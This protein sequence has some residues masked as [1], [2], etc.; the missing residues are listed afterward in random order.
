VA[1]C[2]EKSK[3]LH[4]GYCALIWIAR[5]IPEVPGITTSDMT[6]SGAFNRAAF[7][8]SCGQ[9]KNFAENP[10]ICNIAASVEAMRG[11]S[12]TTKIRGTG[13]EDTYVLFRVAFP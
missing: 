7:K 8:A 13:L 3:I 1:A 6:R 2:P 10:F 12:S 5:S 4:V 11:S 9:V